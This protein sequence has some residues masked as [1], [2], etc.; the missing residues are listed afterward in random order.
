MRKC[1]S[2]VFSV[3]RG[4]AGLPFMNVS[5]VVPIFNEEG[6]IA[7]LSSE[8]ATA[9]KNSQ[10]DYEVIWVNDKSTDG[11]LSELK[12]LNTDK[13]LVVNHERNRG[14]SAALMTGISNSSNE[15]IVTIDGDLQNDPRDILPLLQKLEEGYD[16]VCGVRVN[17]QDEKL[18]TGLSSFANWIA[19]RITKVDVSDLGCTLRAFHK[20]IVRDIEIIGEMHRVL[21][22]YLFLHGA[23]IAEIK[24]NHRPRIF[25]ESKYGYE[26][27]L[28][29]IMDI[30][31]AIFYSKFRDRPLYYFGSISLGV[32]I[33][34]SF[35]EILAVLLRISDIKDYLDT[36][37]II[38]GLILQS[39]SFIFLSLGLI[40]EI[41]IRNIPR[42]L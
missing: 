23:Q 27:I 6:N 4:E 40:A 31:L 11:T 42:R 28:K 38:G 8:I 25:G 9:M 37:L 12:K 26:R 13:N 33:A 7:I 24:V 36:T 1:E 39:S 41:L 15:I 16:V 34:G 20:T 21:V 22:L 3:R 2:E 19:R 10:I 17:R 5:I 30:L 29:F 14:Q 35:L 18:R 32:L